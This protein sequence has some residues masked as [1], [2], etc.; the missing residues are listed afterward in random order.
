M[1]YP[2]T[3]AARRMWLRYAVGV[4]VGRLLQLFR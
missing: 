3:P 2:P 4:G 1:L